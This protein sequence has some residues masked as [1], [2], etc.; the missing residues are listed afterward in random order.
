MKLFNKRTC[1][2]DRSINDSTLPN[3]IGSVNTFEVRDARVIHGDDIY[4][5]ALRLGK[6]LEVHLRRANNFFE[7]DRMDAFFGIAIRA[8]GA[9]LHFYK[10]E[11]VTVLADEIHLSKR[12]SV[13]LCKD[14]VALPRKMLGDLLLNRSAKQAARVGHTVYFLRREGRYL[15]R[16]SCSTSRA[17]SIGTVLYA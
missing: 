8:R 5:P 1:R 17:L 13:L 9:R 15:R 7:L 16:S 6:P 2:H 14:A 12:R 10:N 11:F 4:A 3:P